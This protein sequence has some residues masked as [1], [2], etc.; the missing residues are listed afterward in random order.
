V[1]TTSDIPVAP[2]ANDDC[3]SDLAL[4]TLVTADIDTAAHPHLAACARCRGRF[5]LFAQSK[6][7]ASPRVGHILHNA[8][9]SR[10]NTVRQGQRWL[11]LPRLVLAGT[12]AVCA[13]LFLVIEPHR[14]AEQNL[15][16]DREATA[17]DDIRI[18]GTSLR[19]FRLRDGNVTPR[20]SGD[21]FRS[22]DAL[23]F[24]VSNGMPMFFFLVGIE[25]SGKVSPYYPFGGSESIRL[26]SGTDIALPNSLV[27]DDSRDTEYYVGLFTPAPLTFEQI[28]RAFEDGRHRHGDILSVLRQLDLP[29][30]HH[31]VVVRKE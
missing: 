24:V 13:S 2:K 27:L 22:G 17:S 3:L 9:I 10:R 20:V 19:F 18:K 23:R 5:D 11:T 29:G 21:L 7:I 12:F 8:I 6:Q 25:E 26:D 31:W 28:R 4:D 16:E 15:S 1:T 30:S 14:P